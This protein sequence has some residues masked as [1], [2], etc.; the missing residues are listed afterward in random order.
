MMKSEGLL[1]LELG[2]I[3]GVEEE[4]YLKVSIWNISC[5]TREGVSRRDII[6]ELQGQSDLLPVT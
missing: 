5:R 6:N 1:E 3:E 4:Q 2:R